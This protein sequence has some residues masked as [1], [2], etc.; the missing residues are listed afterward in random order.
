MPMKI[1]LC[2]QLDIFAPV[3]PPAE[4]SDEERLKAVVLLQSLLI[5]AA[6]MTA[7]DEMIVPTLFGDA[8]NRT[9]EFLILPAR[10]L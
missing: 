1:P 2:T 6:S 7:N 4:M 8:Q 3:P 5:E 10:R 9:E